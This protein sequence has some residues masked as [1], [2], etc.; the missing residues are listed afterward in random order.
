ML[1]LDLTNLREQV[2]EAPGEKAFGVSVI[3]TLDSKCLART[4][5]TVGKNRAVVPHEALIYDASANL[6]KYIYLRCLLPRHII[7]GELFIGD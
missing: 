7:E 2:L 6:L 5:L 4:G 3:S 1:I